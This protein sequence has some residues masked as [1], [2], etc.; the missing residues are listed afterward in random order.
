MYELTKKMEYTDFMKRQTIQI[1][2]LN[3]REIDGLSDYVL[4]GSGKGLLSDVCS[5]V[6]HDPR[7]NYT[8]I[9]S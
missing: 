9:I 5:C 7:L 8:D 6:A 1:K 3:I 4:L 2:F